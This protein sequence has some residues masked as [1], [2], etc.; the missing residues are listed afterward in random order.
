MKNEN[1]ATNRSKKA[2]CCSA[3]KAESV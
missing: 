1:D 2:G 3:K